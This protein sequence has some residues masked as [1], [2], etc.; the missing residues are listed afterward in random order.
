MIPR[1]IRRAATMRRVVTDR[2]GVALIEF[3][4]VLP[5]MALLFVGAFQLLD[6]ISAYRKVTVTARALAD[7]TSQE[8]KLTRSDA[9]VILGAARQVMSPY[10]TT[11]AVLRLTQIKVNKNG[12]ATVDWTRA[13][14]GSGIKKKDLHLPD[15]I[16]V[17]QTFVIYAE[18]YF[19]YQPAAGGNLIAPLKFHDGIYM[20]PR[21][22]DSIPCADCS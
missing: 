21:R 10:S 20:N 4:F 9:D 5:F 6:A 17:P 2:R 14:D 12:V 7:L 3:A 15:S 13:S 19:K 1:C 16:A 22:S 11:S 18:I 8:V